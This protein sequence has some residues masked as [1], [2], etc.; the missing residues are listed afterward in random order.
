MHT[1]RVVYVTQK[2]IDSGAKGC[3]LNCPIA[4]ALKAAGLKDLAISPTK[5]A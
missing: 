2:H 1:M 3:A 5:V 4:L